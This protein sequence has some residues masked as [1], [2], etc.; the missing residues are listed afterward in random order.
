MVTIGENINMNW[1][2]IGVMIAV[3]VVQGGIFLAAAKSV[4]ITKNEYEK[5]VKGWNHRLYD[6]DNIT[7]FVPRKEWIESRNE[8]ELR[9]DL[10]QR[11]V[12]T[13]IDKLQE[14]MNITNGKLNKL[15]GRLER[16]KK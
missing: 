10:S 5:N 3:A 11:A 8:R 9:R 13:K 1:D 2:M 6:S 12:C 15:L 14:S 16:E 4:F 7:I